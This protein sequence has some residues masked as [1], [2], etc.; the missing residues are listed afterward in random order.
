ME[1]A[2]YFKEGKAKKMTETKQRE[3]ERKEEGKKK[4]GGDVRR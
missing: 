1:A 4:E 2:K 3:F